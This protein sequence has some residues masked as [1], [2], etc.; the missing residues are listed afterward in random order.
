MRKSEYEYGRADGMADGIAVGRAEGKAEG[1]AEGKAESIIELLKRY[2][3]VPEQLYQKISE[4]K[5]EEILLQWLIISASVKS[6]EEF[7]EKMN[8]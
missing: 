3:E 4:E 2:G 8:G 5:D 7:A 6:I 1:R